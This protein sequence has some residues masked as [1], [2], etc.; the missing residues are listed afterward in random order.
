MG[1][2]HYVD[3][4]F[5]FDPDETLSFYAPY[6]LY[7]PL[8]QTWLLELFDEIGI[9]HE[10]HKQV[11]GQTLIIIRLEV[12]LET[13]SISMSQEK[14]EDLIKAIKKFI[15]GPGHWHPLRDW[16]QILRYCNWGLNAYPLL[17][18]GLQSLYAKLRGKKILLAPIQL[19][20]QVVWDLSWFAHQILVLSGVQFIGAWG[21]HEAE[22]NLTLLSQSGLAFWIPDLNITF[23]SSIKELDLCYG[24]IF[25]NEALAVVSAI[26]WAANLP[27]HPQWILIQLDSMNTVDMFNTLALDQPL[28]PLMIWAVEV[29]MG[30]SGHLSGTYPWF[31]ELGC[32]CIVLF[33]FGCCPHYLP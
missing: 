22:A 27:D 20:K 14:R 8:K 30:H 28:I 24:D 17:R 25:F 33:P 7:Y 15:N 26:K 23:L 18:P 31:G 32:R 12:S 5:S 2:L 29:M 13:M 6:D 19:N 3:D 4:V 21:W 11:F 10:K 9:P 16:Q 1:L